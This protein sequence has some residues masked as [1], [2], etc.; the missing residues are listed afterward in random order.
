MWKDIRF[1]AVLLECATLDYE[2]IPLALKNYVLVLANC[3]KLHNLRE[4]KY[5][6]R[7]NEV[8]FALEV[9]QKGGLQVENLSQV[10]PWQLEPFKQAMGATVDLRAKHVTR[11]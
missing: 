9:L 11:V 4:S 10:K 8:E 1:N 6:E 5:N 2:H 3:N 7:R